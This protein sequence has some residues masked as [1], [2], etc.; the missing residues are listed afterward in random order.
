MRVA[1][2][3]DIHGNLVALE[4]VARDLERLSPDLVIHGGDLALIGP[5]P[6]ESCSHGCINTPTSA[7]SLLYRWARLGD[8]VVV[9][10]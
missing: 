8:V 3:S 10:A 1:V 9:E 6:Q 7:M 5:R 4:A 2:V